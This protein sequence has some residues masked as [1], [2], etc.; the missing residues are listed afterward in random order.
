MMPSANAAI[1][2]TY[3]NT[4]SGGGTGLRAQYYNDGGASY[5]L[6]NPFTGTPA[7][8]RTDPTL[9]FVWGGGSPGSLVTN[10]NF[11]AKWSGKVKAPVTGSYTFTVRGDDGVRLF[12]DGTKVLGRLVRSRSH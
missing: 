3:S 1:T 9:D 4:G 12:I 11:S 2:A 10:N 6:A 8:T 5:P 7:L